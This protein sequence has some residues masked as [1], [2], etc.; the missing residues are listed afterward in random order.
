MSRE[1]WKILV[2]GKGAREHALATSLAASD[3]VDEVVVAPGNGGTAV[4]LRNASI[5]NIDDPAAVVA[6]ARAEEVDLVVVGPEAPLVAGVADAL[7]DAGIAVFGPGA[8]GAQLEGSKSFFKR[9]ARKHGI[10]TADFE[11]FTDAAAAHRYVDEAKRP[12]VVKADG[13]CAGK[14]VVVAK[15][16][17]EAHAAIDRCLVEKAFGDAGATVL[18]EEIILGEEASVHFVTDGK[19]FVLLPTAQDH[20]RLRDGDK[21][22]NT[23]GMG[24]YAPAP[25]VDEEVRE[26]IVDQIIGPTLKGLRAD[27]LDF[28]GVL[29]A[30]LMIN[31]EGDPLMLEYNVR[32]GDPETAAIVPILDEDLAQML[33]DAALANLSA[34]RR[35]NV[36]GH[37]AA[38]VLAAEGYPE[39]PRSGDEIDG[40]DEAAKIEGVYAFH[41][42]TQKRDDKLVTAGGRVFAVS[43]VG[44]TLDEAI[45]AAYRGC[46]K[47]SFRGKLLRRDIGARAR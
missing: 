24:A 15:T 42:G 43:A 5:S 32:F 35:A 23:G 46:D 25:L 2:L 17:E 44:S 1:G 9:F 27:G 45:E 14:G 41:A 7:R 21:G 28:R 37:A 3:R 26:R 31:G 20:K 8:A 11:I 19:S 36:E 13:L 16:A 34:P 10:P 22:P 29:F 40:I 38:V 4:E 18:I 39:S 33:M 30:G 47:I 6:L 12:L